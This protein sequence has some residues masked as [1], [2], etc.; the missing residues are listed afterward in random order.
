MPRSLSVLLEGGPDGIPRILNVLVDRFEDH[1][2]VAYRNGYEHFEFA[3]EF[4][5]IS[6]ERLPVYRWVYRTAIAE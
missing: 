6:D 4:A 1:I 2:K 3:N 5:A